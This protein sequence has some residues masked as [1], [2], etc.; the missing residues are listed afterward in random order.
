MRQEVERCRI[1]NKRRTFA[2]RDQKRLNVRVRRVSRLRGVKSRLLGRKQLRCG[3]NDTGGK[4]RL[5]LVRFYFE[6]AS[7]GRDAIP[8]SL[9][10]S[11]VAELH[12]SVCGAVSEH[13]SR[14]P[15]CWL[16]VAPIDDALPPP[17]PAGRSPS[18][19][20][21]DGAVHRCSR[22]RSA[23]ENRTPF[24]TEPFHFVTD[25]LKSL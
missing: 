13:W 16:S 8:V 6:I 19:G 23:A 21:A 5:T 1:Q 2:S 17:L 11:V 14:T 7:L 15:V 18:H 10:P 12:G 4:D 24:T 22:R 20:P 25:E 3:R 9:T